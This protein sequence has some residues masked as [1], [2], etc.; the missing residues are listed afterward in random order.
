[1]SIL[2]SRFGYAK[3]SVF[4]FIYFAS[5][6]TLIPFFGLYLHGLQLTAVEIAQI[7]AVLSLA[8]LVSPVVWASISHDW[9]MRTSVIRATWLSLLPMLLLWWVDGY[10]ALLLVAGW[11][12]F[13][14]HA[15]LPNFES[16]TLEHLK[17][18]PKD[19]GRIRLWGSLGFIAAV[20]AV[21]VLMQ[22]WGA[23]WFLVSLTLLF[24]LLWWSAWWVDE[25]VAQEE[26]AQGHSSQA[27]HLNSWQVLTHQGMPILM[28]AVLLMQISHGVYYAFYSILL[29]EKG[30]A[31]GEIGALWSLGVL[32]EV[33]MFWWIHRVF[34]LGF[35]LKFWLWF[36]LF[37][38]GVRWLML[39]VG[40]DH[41][42]LVILVQLF[43]AITFALFHSAV[44]QALQHLFPTSGSTQAQA[45]YSSIGYGIGGVLGALVAG[46]L[47][48]Y[49]QQI[50]LAFLFAAVSA[51]LGC[52]IVWRYWT[53]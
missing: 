11:L 18:T 6:G 42:W 52:I 47:W 12:G 41:L 26:A 32:A 7:I 39:A 48:D 3:L 22:L 31:A 23:V 2:F 44:M 21:G 30:Y 19:Y 28:L 4:Y 46:Y 34:A 29:V 10:L 24:L 25:P 14:W 50:S 49:D 5:V 13:F 40:A 15:I 33:L 1:M 45:W 9:G 8:R 37:M 16:L 51:L 35:T 38:A 43:H 36:G 27:Q 53:D 17:K 20:Q